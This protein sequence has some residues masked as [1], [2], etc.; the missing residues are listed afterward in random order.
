MPLGLVWLLLFTAGCV[1]LTSSLT[2][3]YRDILAAMPFLLQVGL[4]LAPVGYPVQG[5]GPVVRKFVELNPLTGVIESL[6]WMMVSGY[7]APSLFVIGV[8]L[9]MTAAVSV[10]GWRTF[11]RLETTM[12]DEI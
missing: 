2:V 3:R 10:V 11:S 7:P 8:S 6:R 1:A 12:G 9:V 5:L 4:F